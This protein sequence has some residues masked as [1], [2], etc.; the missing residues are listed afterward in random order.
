MPAHFHGT[1]AALWEALPSTQRE[2][3]Q[4]AA[5]AARE[6]DGI[7]CLVGGPVRDLLLGTASLRDLDLMTTGDARSIAARFAQRTGGA[8][9]KVTSFGTATVSLVTHEGAASLDFATM[10]TETYPHPGALPVVAFPAPTIEDDLKRRDFT[11]NAMA[12]PLT[13]EGF[14]VLRD[15]FGGLS[16]LQT[17]HIRVLHD[18][19][20]R[21][22]PTRLF[23]GVRYAARY[24]YTFETHTAQLATMAVHDGC[25][26]TISPARK[27]REIELGMRERNRV[28]CL[29]QFHAHGLLRATSPALVWDD[30]VAEH[31]QHVTDRA[32]L[33]RQENSDTSA[34]LWAAFVLR[35]GED[36]MT[37]LFRDVAITEANL[38]TPIRTLVSAFSAW[39]SGAITAEIPFSALAPHVEK[40]AAWIAWEFF[41]EPMRTRLE[42]LYERLDAYRAAPHLTGYDLLR[43]G[44]SKGPEMGRVL[45]ALRAAWLDGSMQTPTD[46]ER[47]VRNRITPSH[48]EGN[49]R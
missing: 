45:A 35:E 41:P 26:D 18:A 29:G 16:D 15:P 10:R 37:R 27:R 43:L 7:A 40:L 34:A 19:S 14:G 6:A 31:V 20:F 1:P 28:G 4:M 11:I 47:F 17:G 39:Q 13:P 48:Y 24:S 21:D 5:T 8:V 42:A 32:E 46:E 38:R 9:E 33:L 12:L 3:L 36:A 30:W 44:V 23:R 2:L 49:T 22:D 25:L